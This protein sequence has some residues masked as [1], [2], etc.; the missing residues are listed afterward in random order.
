L[1]AELLDGERLMSQRPP[2]ARL[3]RVAQVQ[4]VLCERWFNRNIVLIGDAAH[5]AHFSIG[6]GTKLAMEDAIA[7]A[8]VL[9]ARQTARAE[10][11]AAL[12]GRARGRG[13]QAAERGAQ[14]HDLVRA[15]SA[16]S[17]SSPSSSP[18]S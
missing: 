8:A 2:P 10:R 5:T 4:P 13:A 3:G 11:L 9:H 7:L 17:R 16:T 12:P 15:S 1:F 18:R 14:P 6:S